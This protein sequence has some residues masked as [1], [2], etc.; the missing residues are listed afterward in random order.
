MAPMR[1]AQSTISGMN[2][3]DIGVRKDF[4]DGKLQCGLNLSDV[5]NIRQFN[6]RQDGTN[7]TYDGMRKRESRVLTFSVTY[8]IGSK[9][10]PF[11]KKKPTITMPTENMD[12]G[13]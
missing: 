9:D 4:Y 2:G 10:N 8:R 13:F 12:M 7:F 11:T 6:I 3:L 1:F 5:F